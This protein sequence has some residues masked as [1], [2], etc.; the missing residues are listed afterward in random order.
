MYDSFYWKHCF[1]CSHKHQVNNFP[2]YSAWIMNGSINVE[3]ETW[4]QISTLMIYRIRVS[5]QIIF[6][7]I[8]LKGITVSLRQIRPNFP[9]KKKSSIWKR[10]MGIQEK[11]NCA[12]Q[13]VRSNVLH[14]LGWIFEPLLISFNGQEINSLFYKVC[15]IKILHYLLSDQ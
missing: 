14:K 9:A 10:H 8:F 3:I 15:W 1:Y 4:V 11:K 2:T 12:Q 13:L 6:E 7:L 5:V